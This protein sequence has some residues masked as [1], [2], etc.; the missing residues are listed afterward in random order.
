M[1][2]GAT[3]LALSVTLA[4][5]CWGASCGSGS[6]ASGNP[7]SDIASAVCQRLAACSPISDII[8]PYG[9]VDTCITRQRVLFSNLLTASGSG[10]TAA[11]LEACAAAT[12][13]L[14]CSALL[15][16]DLPAACHPPGTRPDGASCA[17]G[18]Q[19]QSGTCLINRALTPAT[20]CGTCG[21][22]LAAPQICSASTDCTWGS[23]CFVP[24]GSCGALSPVGAPC[25]APDNCERGLTCIQERCASPGARWRAVH[26]QRRLR[27]PPRLR[28]RR[29]D[30]HGAAV[31]ER[32]SGM[33]GRRRGHHALRGTGHLR[34]RRHLPCGGQRRGAVQSIDGAE[35]YGTSPM[36][37]RPVQ[38]A[39]SELPLRLRLRVRAL[40]V[41]TGQRETLRP[42][43][44]PRRISIVCAASAEWVERE[45][46]REVVD[47]FRVPVRGPHGSAARVVERVDEPHFIE[48]DAERLIQTGRRRCKGLSAA[49]GRRLRGPQSPRRARPGRGA[50]PSRIALLRSDGESF[51]AVRNAA[52]Q[53][54]GS[55]TPTRSTS[56]SGR[57]KSRTK[58]R[59]SA[60][61]FSGTGQR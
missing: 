58:A 9:D 59:S 23:A 57:A 45:L 21:A 18:S 60:M 1:S 6:A 30:L 15:G 8:E 52:T 44:E 2:T 4:V 50:C 49:R 7:T 10:W 19:C 17:D 32:G 38:R 5:A 37:R 24:N 12:G 47:W 36:H 61:V 56:A 13:G 51:A 46:P 25:V 11:G 14:A 41:R 53:S 20:G 40:P 34:A 28:L 42:T 48:G 43:A 35:L 16:H 33:R 3:G 54:C 29:R 39:G 26:L 31:R 27:L 22:P 55:E